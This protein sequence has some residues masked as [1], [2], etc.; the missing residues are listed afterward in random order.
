M[1]SLRLI[2]CMMFW[3]TI[4][5]TVD[6]L[7]AQTATDYRSW[8]DSPPFS[9]Y[10]LKIFPRNAQT[11][12]VEVDMQFY[13]VA[14]T[15][16]NELNGYLDLVGY[17]VLTWTNE[18]LMWNSSI[19]AMQEVIL[20]QNNFWRPSLVLSN[21]VESLTEMGDNSYK[22]RINKDGVCEWQIGVVSKSACS[23]DV[24]YYPFDKQ[25]CKISF[26]PWGYT[27]T[28]VRLNTTSTGMNTDLFM[29]NVEWTL[30][31]TTVE[32]LSSASASYLDYSLNLARK[33]GY[34]LVNMII[35]IL[36][37][38]M[39]NGLVFLLP[40]DSGERVGYAI[41]AFLTFAVFLTMVSDNLPKSSE[42]MSLLCFFL[43]LMLIM[44]ALSTV[45]TIMTLR[46]YHQ[47][48]DSPVPMW[49]KHVVAFITCRKCKKWCGQK[50]EAIEEPKPGQ[51][52]EEE[53]SSSEEEEEEDSDDEGKRKT[54]VKKAKPNNADIKGITW[55]VVGGTLD[56]FFFSLFVFGTVVISCV[57]LIPLA[58]AATSSSSDEE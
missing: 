39:L 16:L 8:I 18:L 45:I 53:E 51:E 14:I 49:L 46:V 32:A 30:T 27:D 2:Q 24:S 23:V 50:L 34:F 48:D 22:I 9:T 35:P 54:E 58:V 43:T 40:A 52:V 55:R 38:G 28:Q 44:S 56:G 4:L 20:G 1:G 25:V 5:F 19:N 6:L 7:N 15:Q 26:T 42:P 33:P 21:S 41:T 17:T 12:K 3:V 10:N 13:L 29:P 37:L 31:S 57:F 11:D 47:D 36:I